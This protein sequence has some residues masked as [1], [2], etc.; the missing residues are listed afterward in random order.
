[1]I[2]HR[3]FRWVSLLS[4]FALGLIVGWLAH[5]PEQALDGQAATQQPVATRK[6]PP[7]STSS[8]PLPSATETRQQSE[9]NSSLALTP[10][11]RA[12][13]GR[14]RSVSQAQGPRVDPSTGLP[15]GENISVPG[16][17]G[18]E[19]LD[20]LM[21]AISISCQFDS[22]QGAAWRGDS[23]S[24]MSASWQGGLIVYDS[25]DFTASSA[26]MTGSEGATGSSTGETKMRVAVTDNGIHFTSF[27][28]RGDLMSTTV[29]PSTDKRG[30]Y[31]AVMS[32]HSREFNH[33]SSQFYGLCDTLP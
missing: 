26:R 7:A 6:L 10:M 23:Y 14:E 25:M 19:G 32:I 21:G 16:A 17:Q 30:R 20:D 15:F 31:I 13:A 2:S 8:T 11:S 28:P 4:V 5:Q 22:G 3:Q 33:Y 18:N 1:M 27:V 9:E 24:I 12:S 29:F